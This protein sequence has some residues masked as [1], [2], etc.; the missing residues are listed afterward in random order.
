MKDPSRSSSRKNK[1]TIS[2][3]PYYESHIINQP[4]NY[5]FCFY[6]SAFDYSYR[7][8][9]WLNSVLNPG[10][11]EVLDPSYRIFQFFILYPLVFLLLRVSERVIW[12]QRSG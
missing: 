9:L 11:S 4:M 6:F 12:L 2:A 7:G 1:G 8:L 3:Y 10:P 5:I